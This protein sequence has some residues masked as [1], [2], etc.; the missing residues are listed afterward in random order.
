MVSATYKRNTGTFSLSQGDI[1][2]AVLRGVSLWWVRLYGNSNC[3]QNSHFLWNLFFRRSIWVLLPLVHRR[4]RVE[5]ASTRTNLYN[6]NNNSNNNNN[7]N[8]FLLG[9]N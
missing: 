3:L 2:Y 5:E 7:N 8:N 6:N 9:T 4:T 1:F